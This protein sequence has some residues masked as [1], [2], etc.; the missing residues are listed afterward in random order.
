MCAHMYIPD[1]YSGM[2]ALQRRENPCP[3]VR[4][5]LHTTRALAA[6]AAGMPLRAAMRVA[7]RS[8]ERKRAV[9]NVRAP[10]SALPTV[11]RSAAAAAQEF[12]KF[13]FPLGGD[14]PNGLMH[15]T[16]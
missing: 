13:L 1:S 9:R 11:R 15:R 5:C 4:V 12:P 2:D 14:G 3:T 7:D 6:R 8:A 16:R 10:S